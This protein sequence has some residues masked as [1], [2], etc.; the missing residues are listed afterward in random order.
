[1]KPLWVSDFLGSSA[2]RHD[3]LVVRDL[4]LDGRIEIW[5]NMGSNGLAMY[6]VLP[7]DG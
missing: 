4:D 2:G 6:E 5:V 3:S 1:M 7:S